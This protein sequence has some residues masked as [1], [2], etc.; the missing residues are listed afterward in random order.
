MIFLELT[1]KEVATILEMVETRLLNKPP[2]CSFDHN[3]MVSEVCK[4]II[5]KITKSKSPKKDVLITMKDLSTIKSM[6][7]DNYNHMSPNLQISNKKV[8]KKDFVHISLA[9]AFISWLN[10]KQLL[11]NLVAF[12]CTDDSAEYEEDF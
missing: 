12:D 7:V 1:Q 6:A 11:K 8:D 3:E 2:G 10:N 4:S 9:N 5:E